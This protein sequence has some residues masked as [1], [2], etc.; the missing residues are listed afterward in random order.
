MDVGRWADNREAASDAPAVAVNSAAD[1]IWKR[2]VVMEAAA[3]WRVRR[4]PA[5]CVFAG[6]TQYARGQAP[7]P[8]L[9]KH[10]DVDWLADGGAGAVLDVGTCTVESWRKS[11]VRV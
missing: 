2:V 1:R 11:K 7:S 6:H 8:A 9:L 5:A 4:I 3:W 10:V